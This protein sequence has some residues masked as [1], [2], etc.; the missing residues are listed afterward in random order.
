MERDCVRGE[1]FVQRV[2]STGVVFGGILSRG[3]LVLH[4]DP[5]ELSFREEG[6]GRGRGG[7]HDGEHRQS[8]PP[9]NG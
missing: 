8:N 5:K 4:S 3:D 6:G 2:F 7:Q 1:A 9:I